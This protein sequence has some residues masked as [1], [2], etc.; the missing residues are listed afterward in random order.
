MDLILIQFTSLDFVASLDGT[1]GEAYQTAAT[2]LDNYIGQI[3]RVMNLD[4]SVLIILSDH[5]HLSSGGHGGTEL[6]VIQQ[7]LII[8]GRGIKPGQYSL[9]SQTDIA[10][11]VATLLGLAA[12][13]ISQG[14]ILFEMLNLSLEDQTLAQM[15]LARQRINLAEDYLTS[16]IGPEAVLPDSLPVDLDRAVTTFSQNNINGAF[17]LALL[18]QESADTQIELARHSRIQAEQWPRLFVV[19]VVVLSW[20][21]IM[22]R[23]RNTHAGLILVATVVTVALYHVLFQLQG[24]SYSI[25]TF[26]DLL[27]L[28][29]D[30]ARRMVVSFLAGGAL[31]LIFLMLIDE[32]DWATLLNTGFGFSIFT[33]FV[34]SLPLLWA[35]WQNGFI[36]RWHYPSVD[37]VF[38][39][40]ISLLEIFVA[41]IIG[42][43]LPWPI[44]ALNVFVNF[45][46]RQLSGSQS[47]SGRDPLPGLR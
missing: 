9:I 39:Q 6:E 44:M 16:I 3:S 40:V 4:N 19:A 12:P 27:Q 13:P 24:Y 45:I 46:R 38:W 18:T 41:A 25:S 30:V 5:G 42:L 31:V 2:R 26:D 37:L 29:F 28:P 43:I 17:Q 33:I 47:E 34:L 23:R 36:I 7:P 10:P 22:W 32:R 14:R 1:S 21:F 35:F 20:F 11:T 15:V 8:N